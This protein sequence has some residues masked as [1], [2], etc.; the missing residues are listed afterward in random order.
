MLKLYEAKNVGIALAITRLFRQNRLK[1][2]D[3]E[4]GHLF[5]YHYQP[6][7]ILLFMPFLKILMN[8]IDLFA[9]KVKNI[10]TVG[11]VDFTSKYAIQEMVERP[12]IRTA[13][14]IIELGGGNGCITEGILK[15]MQQPKAQL[16]SFEINEKFCELLQEIKDKRLTVIEDSAE[17]MELY[18]DKKGIKQADVILSSIPVSIMPDEVVEDIFAIAK[19]RLKP[20]GLFIQIQYSLLSKKLIEKTFGPVDMSWVARN[21]PPAFI[22]VS[23][24]IVSK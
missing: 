14:C 18:M 1:N 17:K 21:V 15:E 7:T 20:N 10:K 24:N 12:E 9:E 4:N 3:D 11:A 23:K 8:R 22:M 16:L 2:I 5:F 19:K 13:Q 6:K